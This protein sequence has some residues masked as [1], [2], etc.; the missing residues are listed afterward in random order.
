MKRNLIGAT[1]IALSF[2]LAACSGHGMQT[3]PVQPD[4]SDTSVIKPMDVTGG[5]GPSRLLGGALSLLLGDAK[6]NLGGQTLQHLNIGI[7]EIDAVSDGVSTTL[8]KYDTPRI[9]D[10]LAH[11][12]DSGESVAQGG[13]DVKTYQQLRFV[14]DVATT[15]AMFG[16]HDNRSINFLTGTSTFSTVQAGATTVTTADG[17]GAVDVV[18]TQPFT[19]AADQDPKVRVDFNAYESVAMLQNGTLVAVPALFVSPMSDIGSIRGRVVSGQGNPVQ[20][21]TIVAVAA[22]GSIGNTTFTNDDGRFRVGTLRSGT[23]Q[24]MIYNQYTTASGQHMSAN[25][26]SSSAS[27]I[28]GPAVTVTGNGQTTAVGTLAD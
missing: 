13:G 11:Q 24:L 8:A 4:A 19:V 23:Y 12:D 14:I 10:V 20:N 6:P 15:Q 22:D 25:G 28:T 3:T 2:G 16:H 9:V 18:V 5:I 21:A 17:P 27:V 1:A 26:A 7:R